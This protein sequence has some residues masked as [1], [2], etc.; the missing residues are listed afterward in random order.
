MRFFS[1]LTVVFALTASLATAD[2]WPNWRGPNHSGAATGGQYPADLADPANLAVC[3]KEC[4][5]RKGSIPY[6]EF[7]KEDGGGK[8]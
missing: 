5:I 8:I 7:I 6:E 3:C 2:N 4:N 1:L